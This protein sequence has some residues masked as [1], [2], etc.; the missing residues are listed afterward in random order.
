MKKPTRNRSAFLWDERQGR[1]VP[2]R[3]ARSSANESNHRLLLRS[4]LLLALLA[5]VTA[6]YILWR[7]QPGGAI[8]LSAGAE[9]QAGELTADDAMATATDAAAPADTPEPTDIPAWL[10]CGDEAGALRTDQVKSAVLGLALPVQVYLPPCYDDAQYAYPTLYL[11]QGLGYTIGQWVNDGAAR[12]AD[13]GILS[14]RLPPFIMVMPANDW[15]SG[16][17]SRYSYTS[18]GKG[19]WEDFIVNEL[20]PAMDVRY[21]TWD[22]RAGRAIGGISR[23]GYWSLEIAFTHTDLF[24]AAGGHS[25]AITPDYLVGTPDDFTMLDLVRSTRTLKSLRIF[26]DAGTDDVTQTGVYQLAAE[27][28]ARQIP[29]T[30]RIGSGRHDDAYWSAQM[31]EYLAFYTLNW[32]QQPR[33]RK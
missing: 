5:A 3:S 26:L 10:D 31:T 11:I 14:G 15:M 9:L 12:D 23:G 30:G 28:G 22:N 29:Y 13:Q 27:L 19:S 4:L 7:T 24:S 1:P 25:P 16:S 17:N 2:A 33:G 20:V 21:S 18:R 8:N 32:P 6:V